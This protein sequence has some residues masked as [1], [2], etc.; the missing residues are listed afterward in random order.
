MSHLRAGLL[1]DP[2]EVLRRMSSKQQ[3]QRRV[4]RLK[5]QYRMRNY[6]LRVSQLVATLS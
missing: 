5:H 1:V 6:E 3:P 2:T 4:V